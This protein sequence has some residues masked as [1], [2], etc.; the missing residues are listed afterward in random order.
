M[1]LTIAAPLLLLCSTRVFAQA[2][3]PAK[4]VPSSSVKPR[5][6]LKPATVSGSVF[7][8]TE[9]G[10]IKPA[11]MAD[12]YM[13]YSRPVEKFA[14]RQNGQSPVAISAADEFKK[15]VEHQRENEKALEADKPGMSDDVRC[16]FTI[17]RLSRGAILETLHW[18]NDGGHLTEIVTG[19]TDEEGKFEI[20]TPPPDLADVTFEPRPRGNIAFAP[21]VYLVVVI[22]SAGYY[23][24]FWEG[25]VTLISGQV[26][27]IKLSEPTMACVKYH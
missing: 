13:L 19:Q 26:V 4:R 8:L 1:N 5:Q 20:V 15:A 6:I 22:G 10:D 2:T 24:A 9:G 21:G 11:R 17:N 23:N 18:G 25:E 14:P 12:V 27:K 7:A 3:L 16:G